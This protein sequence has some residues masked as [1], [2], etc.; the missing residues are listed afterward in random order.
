VFSINAGFLSGTHGDQSNPTDGTPD[1]QVSGTFTVEFSQLP[2]QF[3]IPSS[4]YEGPVTSWDLTFGDRAGNTLHDV[5]GSVDGITSSGRGSGD[6]NPLDFGNHWNFSLRDGN[7]SLNL[8]GYNGTAGP[9]FD[10]KMIPFCED[11]RTYYVDPP[12]PIFPGACETTSLG[13]FGGQ[14][15]VIYTV[16]PPNSNS[17][18]GLPSGGAVVVSTPE[19]SDLLLSFV[20][21]VG[22]LSLFRRVGFRRV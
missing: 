10:G 19:S 17:I 21:V 3:G 7:F 4:F 15:G 13:S 20:G 14:S 5:V 12:S 11:I 18:F 8:T 16:R 9:L 6:A 2:P 1:W 22:C